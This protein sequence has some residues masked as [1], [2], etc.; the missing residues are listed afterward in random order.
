MKKRILNDIFSFIQVSKFRSR[1][2]LSPI[3]GGLNMTN[4][5]ST[6]PDVEGDVTIPSHLYYNYPLYWMLPESFLGDKVISNITKTCRTE[7]YIMQ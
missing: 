3:N 2:F 5:L 6:I 7:F 4:G 1:I